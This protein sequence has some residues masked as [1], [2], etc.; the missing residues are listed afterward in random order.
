MLDKSDV[1]GVMLYYKFIKES[2]LILKLKNYSSG[3]Q[4]FETGL[5][6][7]KSSV[8]RSR[9]LTESYKGEYIFFPF[10]V[11]RGFLHS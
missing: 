4:K 11:S 6:G 7:I 5:T 3:S 1:F 9:F 2:K 8:S 10:P